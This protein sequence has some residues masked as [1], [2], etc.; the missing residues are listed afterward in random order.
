MEAADALL[1]P[2]FLA[3]TE[4]YATV[5]IIPQQPPNESGYTLVCSHLACLWRAF[6]QAVFLFAQLGREGV[7]EV[8]GFVQRADFEAGTATAGGR[9]G[10]AW[11]LRWVT[12]RASASRLRLPLAVLCC[13]SCMSSARRVSA[14][15][16][17]TQVAL[18][19][20]M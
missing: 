10:A 11:F 9:I 3:T 1:H 7:A 18:L 20:N 8:V 19:L 17:V 2:T 5:S 15:D 6:A 12:R 4:T 13:N 14:S 16:R